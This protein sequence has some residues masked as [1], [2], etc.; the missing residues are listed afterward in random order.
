MQRHFVRPDFQDTYRELVE[1]HLLLV[2]L[3]VVDL[4]GRLAMHW[5]RARQRRGIRIGQL[6]LGFT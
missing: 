4:A 6:P 1:A 5:F 3:E 2:L